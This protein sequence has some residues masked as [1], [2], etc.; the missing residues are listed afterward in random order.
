LVVCGEIEGSSVRHLID[1]N[2]KG[3]VPGRQ[4]RG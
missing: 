2:A 3:E 4:E 1:S